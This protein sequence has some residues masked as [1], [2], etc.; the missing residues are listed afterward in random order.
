MKH[1]NIIF[2][3]LMACVVMLSC[4]EDRTQEFFDQTKENQWTYKT[5][6]THYLW[7]DQIKPQERSK[8]FVPE[9]NFFTSLLYKSDK[10]SFFT[11][12]VKDGDYGISS[13]LM[14][15]PILVSPSKV[16]AL[17]IF[18]EPG[19]PADVAGIKRG[20]WIS[21]I[22]GNKLSMSSTKDL[23]SGGEIALA[24]E[25]IEYDDENNPFWVES[26][27]LTVGEALPYD[28]QDV[29]IDTVYT[30]R[31]KTIGY[32]L[33]NGFYNDGFEETV[34][35]ISEKFIAG[36]VTD[37]II[38]LRYNTG[39]SISHASY[40]ASTLVSMNKGG[41]PFCTL[42][43]N[44]NEVDTVYNYKETQY[45]LC[46][47]R[48]FFITGAATKGVAELLISSVNSARGAYEVMTVGET[49]AASNV[50]TERIESPY[51]FSINPATAYAYSSDGNIVSADGITPDYELGEL[52]QKEQIVYPLG[53]RQEYLLYNTVYIIANGN[54]PMSNSAQ[55]MYKVCMPHRDGYL[56]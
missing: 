6:K 42:K 9:S 36:N 52:A 33:C 27:T 56:R 26:D 19:S 34:D 44:D 39:G 31:E 23:Q 4:G 14:R 37:V 41:T 43:K 40:L 20:M 55:S 2:V 1:G 24:T 8:F 35:R 13:V 28:L 22:S 16:Y 54:L 29:C 17:V 48:I 46:D 3:Y 47:K 5:M 25:Y 7:K 50:M 10:A 32:I 30:E 15:D 18:V 12:A 49:T 45:T 38:D 21:A 11:S 53:N 51:G